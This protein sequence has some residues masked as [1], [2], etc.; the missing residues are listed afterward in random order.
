ML[1]PN[2]TPPSCVQP[3]GGACVVIKPQK[4]MP[5]LAEYL[6][7]RIVDVSS[8]VELASRWFP[9]AWKRAPKKSFAHTAMSD[10]RES[11]AELRYYKQTV[12]KPPPNP[13][14]KKH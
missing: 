5:E 4:D 14:S 8:I 11:L 1:R 13:S 12:F 9:N 6:H 2:Y 7:Y 3:C 10:I